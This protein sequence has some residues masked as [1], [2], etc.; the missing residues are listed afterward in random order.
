MC[1]TDGSGCDHDLQLG[2]LPRLT[3]EIFHGFSMERRVRFNMEGYE[4]LVLQAMPMPGLG[5][6]LYEDDEDAGAARKRKVS[7]AKRAKI[8]EPLRVS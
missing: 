6:E 4:G 2:W 5:M 7:K 1:D 3:H 8:S